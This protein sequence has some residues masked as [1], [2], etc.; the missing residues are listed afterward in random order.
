MEV[1]HLK[2]KK[3]DLRDKF[4]KEGA[5]QLKN[6][7]VNAFSIRDVSKGLDV[8]HMA[9][10]R[11]FANKSDLLAC[12]CASHFNL[13]TKDINELIKG[14]KVAFDLL[15]EI[16]QIQLAHALNQTSIFR[17]FYLSTSKVNSL[18]FFNY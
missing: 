5:K 11:H 15:L 6:S 18:S 13:I 16:S 1:A 2:T 17:L 14:N 8:S 9:A 12:I 7:G 4:L 3:R 10:Y